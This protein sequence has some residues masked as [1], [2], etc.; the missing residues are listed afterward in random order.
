MIFMRWSESIIEYP[1]I[2]VS[3]FDQDVHH[4]N[5]CDSLIMWSV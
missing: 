1:K 2:S 5:L 4:T 3:M